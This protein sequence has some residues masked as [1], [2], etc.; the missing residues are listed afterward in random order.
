MSPGS[1]CLDFGLVAHGP[2]GIGSR[3]EL[4]V[5]NA[6]W[7]CCRNPSFYWLSAVAFNQKQRTSDA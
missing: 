1:D 3:Y 5:Y 4:E 7:P 6:P 2:Q